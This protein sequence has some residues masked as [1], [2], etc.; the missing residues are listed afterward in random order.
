MDIRTTLRYLGVPIK[1]PSFVFGD[2]ESVMNSISLPHGKLHKRHNALSYHR[3]REDE[4]AGITRHHHLPGT[5]NPSD[6]LSK[7]WAYSDVWPVLR[8]LLFWEYDT[9]DIDDEEIIEDGGKPKPDP[10]R[11]E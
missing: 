11:G 4:A 10:H 7:H 5:K 9:A 2:N 1:G 8:P 6:V 3:T